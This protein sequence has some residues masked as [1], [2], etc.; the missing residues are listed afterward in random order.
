MEGEGNV[1]RRTGSIPDTVSLIILVGA[2]L[3][4]LAG[5]FLLGWEAL[6]VVLF[7]WWETLIFGV[8]VLLK[9]VLVRYPILHFHFFKF[10]WVPVFCFAYFGVFGTCYGAFMLDLFWDL[11]NEG[12]VKDLIAG[13]PDNGILSI[14]QDFVIIVSYNWW[15][16]P[17]GGEWALLSI[18]L[19]HGFEFVQGYVLPGRYLIEKEENEQESLGL[20]TFL[21]PVGLPLALEI[22]VMQGALILGGG[23]CMALNSPLPFLVVLVLVKMGVEVHFHGLGWKLRERYVVLTSPNR[24]R[25]GKPAEG[26][27]NENP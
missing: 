6:D 20:L 24:Q 11:R 22:G 21:K 3:F 1:L 8:F 2:N 14:L 10:I 19:S 13:G 18:A 17:P 4:P 12:S 15:T 26:I 27:A 7:Y 23:L 16:R 5:V 25:N 9:M